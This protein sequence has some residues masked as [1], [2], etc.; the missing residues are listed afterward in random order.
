ML[1]T[2]SSPT[3]SSKPHSL[4]PL[5]ALLKPLCLL[6]PL[7]DGC[8]CGQKQ[9]LSFFLRKSETTACEVYIHSSQCAMTKYDLQT[10]LAVKPNAHIEL[11]RFSDQAFTSKS[12]SFPGSQKLF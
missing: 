2:S 10:L 3:I 5:L 1:P 8:R 12:C 4:C 11:D 9:Y 7:Q 6:S